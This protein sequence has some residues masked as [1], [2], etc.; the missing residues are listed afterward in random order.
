[1][2]DG[3]RRCVDGF[4]GYHYLH[5]RMKAFGCVQTAGNTQ[6]CTPS[7]SDTVAVIVEDD[8]TII[9]FGLT[10]P[11]PEDGTGWGYQLEALLSRTRFRSAW[12]ALLAF[13]EQGLGTFRG[14][15]YE[16][17]SAVAR[18]Q[19]EPL[20]RLHAGQ[21]SLRRILSGRLPGCRPRCELGNPDA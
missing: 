7:I 19:G 6:I 3:D 11:T 20:R 21:L 13:R 17:R 9:C 2:T 12:A 14:A 15:V 4:V 1:L 8:P 18:L 5:Q 16:R 10:V